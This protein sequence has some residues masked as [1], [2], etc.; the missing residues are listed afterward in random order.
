MY[1]KNAIENY[2]VPP[3]ILALK[4][5]GTIVKKIKSKK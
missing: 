5:K 4:P 2:T 1:R 3:E